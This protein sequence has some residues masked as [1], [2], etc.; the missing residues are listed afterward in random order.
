MPD[1]DINLTAVLVAAIVNMVLG[2]LWYSRAV[3]GGQWIKLMG[4]KMDDIG[5]PGPAYALTAVGALLQAYIM[6]HFVQYAAADTIAEGIV[7]GIL[8]WVAFSGITSATT[9]LFSGGKW[10]LWSI[11]NVYFLVVFAINGAILA[12]WQ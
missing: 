3:F 11:N 7:T 10:K 6:A 5:A 8:L 2:F 4:K 12:G 1:V 9:N